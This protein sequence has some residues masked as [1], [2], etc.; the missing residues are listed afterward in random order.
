MQTPVN[1][2]TSARLA[3]NACIS[4]GNM[5]AS[6]SGPNLREAHVSTPGR[7]LCSTGA[8]PIAKETAV[9]SEMADVFQNL[10][11]FCQLI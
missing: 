3:S 5:G 2:T 7:K 6:A 8:Y 11:Q 4:C 1:C 10:F 9:D